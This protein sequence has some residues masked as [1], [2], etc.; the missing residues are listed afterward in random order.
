M[1]SMAVRARRQLTPDVMLMDLLMPN[2]DGLTAIGD[3][4]AGQPE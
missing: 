3:D 2:M 1:A 4:Q